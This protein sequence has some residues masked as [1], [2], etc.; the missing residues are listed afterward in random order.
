MINKDQEVQ[1]QFSSVTVMSNSLWPH[2]LQHAWLPCVA[3][4]PRAYSN[5]CPLSLWCHPTISFCLP[6][7]LPSVI[8]SIR[9]FSNESVLHIRW[10]KYW[11]FSLVL[12]NDL[13]GVWG[14][15]GS[16]GTGYMYTYDRFTSLYRRNEHNIVK[17]LYSNKKT[18]LLILLY[19]VGYL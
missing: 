10:P 15:G 3:P 16:R 7:L 5:S 19:V 13:D 2:G 1:L 12:C 8:P 17:Q 14:E 6:L 4:T 11:S 18:R 9:I